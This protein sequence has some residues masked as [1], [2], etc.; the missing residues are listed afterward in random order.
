MFFFSSRRRH[1]ILQG[2]WSSDVC[3]SDLHPLRANGEP[4]GRAFDVA[5]DVDRSVRRFDRGPNVKVAVRGPRVAHR[6]ARLFHQILHAETSLRND[7]PA[8]SPGRP[9]Y[10]PTVWPMSANVRRVPSG[11]GCTLGPST[12]SG[13]TSRE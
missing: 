2:D 11:T 13:T 3:S 5:A 9:K 10:S 8:A 7:V 1:T 4:V 12:S 6:V